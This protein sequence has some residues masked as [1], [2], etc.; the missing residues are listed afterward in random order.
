MVPFFVMTDY[1]ICT[2][3]FESEQRVQYFGRSSRLVAEVSYI[4]IDEYGVWWRRAWVLKN[5]K[6][7]YLRAEKYL[8]DLC[9]VDLN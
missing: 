8:M 5:P 4:L 7:G 9:L 6:L 2:I 3:E 1:F